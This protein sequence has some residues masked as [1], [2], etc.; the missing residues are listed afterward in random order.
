MHESETRALRRA[1]VL[2]IVISALRWGWA[3]RDRAPAAEGDTVLPELLASSREAAEEEAQRDA[4][5]A[6]GDRVDPNR[7]DEVEL[8]RLPG[9]GPSTARA[10]VAEREAGAVFRTPEDLLT[11][12]GIGPATLGKIRE[13]LLLSGQPPPRARLAGPDK[14]SPSSTSRAAPV[15]LNSADLGGL[16]GLP[17]I[18]PAIAERIL[19][20]RREQPFISLE[21]LLRVRGIGP[22]TLERLGPYATV[23]RQAPR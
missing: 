1:A 23:G 17:G 18:G 9:V 7:A 13:F 14:S 15:D 20:A 22:A 12:R 21:D 2:L 3:T 8:D 16:Q 19:V 5:L 11:I 6:E 4:P 10:I